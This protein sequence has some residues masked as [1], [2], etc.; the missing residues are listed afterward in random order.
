MTSIHI[1]GCNVKSSNHASLK[2]HGE[3]W[4]RQQ[5]NRTSRTRDSSMFIAYG[6]TDTH[7]SFGL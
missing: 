2:R 4:N 6:H 7:R 5:F 1:L 3:K